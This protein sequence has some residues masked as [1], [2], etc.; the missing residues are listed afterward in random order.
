MPIA[1]VSPSLAQAYAQQRKS[2]ADD[3]HARIVMSVPGNK[4]AGEKLREN[5]ATA[6]PDPSTQNGHKRPL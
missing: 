6:G 2:L 5:N 1:Y 4:S 3:P